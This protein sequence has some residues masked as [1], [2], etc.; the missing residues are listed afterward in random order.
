ML[1]YLRSVR[2]E[3]AHVAWPSPRETAI[4]T[5]L[6]ILI[7]LATGAYLGLFDAI[8]LWLLDRLVLFS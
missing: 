6:V 7:S 3:L 8:F 2:E 1:A 5:T 4:Y